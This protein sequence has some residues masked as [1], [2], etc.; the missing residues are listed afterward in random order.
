MGIDPKT[1]MIYLPTVE[2]GEQKDAK[3]RPIAK[4]NTF[5]ILVAGPSG[6]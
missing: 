3:G 4:P 5:M 6:S 2:F 1:H